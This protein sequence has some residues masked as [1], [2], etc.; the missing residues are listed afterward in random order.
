MAGAAL[1]GDLEWQKQH[2]VDFEDLQCRLRVAGAALELLWRR[3][4][5]VHALICVPSRMLLYMCS[6]CAVLRVLLH[7]CA[8]GLQ[9]SRSLNLDK[10]RFLGSLWSFGE[11]GQNGY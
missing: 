3:S 8:L 5:C 11:A 4:K 1:L 7:V 9:T 10:S 2:F 6:V